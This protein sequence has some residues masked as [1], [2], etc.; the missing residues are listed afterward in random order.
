VAT[1]FWPWIAVGVG[2]GRVTDLASMVSVGVYGVVII[3]AI[4]VSSDTKTQHIAYRSAAGVALATAFLLTW[5]IPA[6]GVLGHDGDPVDLMYMGG[7]GRRVHWALF[8]RFQPQGMA[9]ALLATALAQA[10]VAV[11]ALMH[12]STMSSVGEILR[13]NGFFAALW[14]MSAWLF[15]HAAR[16]PF[17]KAEFDG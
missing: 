14:A 1:F 4:I 8:A 17:A 15:R 3:G 7:D 6:V 10:L 16:A 12:Q 2:I 11:I 9:R 5:M 13:L